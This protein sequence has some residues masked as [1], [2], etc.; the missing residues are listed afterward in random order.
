MQKS[1]VSNASHEL[2]TPLTSITGQIEVALMK[3]RSDVEYQAILNSLLED[4]RNL[5]AL[6]NG[7]LDM[8]KASSDPSGITIQ[9]V[10]IDEILWEARQEMTSRKPQYTVSIH[11]DPSIEE[12]TELTVK[13]N[14]QLLKSAVLNLL[15]NGCKFSSDHAAEVYLSTSRERI[16]IRFS[17]KGMGI[18]KEEMEKIF[19][20]F[21]RAESARN[22]P[23]SGLGLPLTYLIIRLHGG[24]LTI[25]SVPREGTTVT[26]TL[27][28][29][30]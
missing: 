5:N 22:I 20:P 3:T 28:G 16:A 18:S 12:E 14:F 9:P 2:R 11:F 8:A 21:Y 27:P 25:D 30:G 23:G 1:F 17:D 24:E 4:T 26:V 15:E 29:M 6:A 19:Q 7:L 10:R 13:G